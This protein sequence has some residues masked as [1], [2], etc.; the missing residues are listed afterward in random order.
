MQE[1]DK[2]DVINFLAHKA[3][4]NREKIKQYNEDHNCV[5]QA[6]KKERLYKKKTKQK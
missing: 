5:E 1:E 2:K 6:E 3:R 4:K